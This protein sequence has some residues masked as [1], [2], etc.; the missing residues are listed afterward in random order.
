MIDKWTTG[1]VIVVMT[2]MGFFGA[3]ASKYKNKLE[4]TESDLAAETLRADAYYSQT[5]ALATAYRE[6]AENINDV[7]TQHER[8][9]RNATTRARAAERMLE[10]IEVGECFD[11]PIAPAVI[12][13]LSESACAMSGLPA[14]SNLPGDTGRAPG[15]GTNATLT[16][17]D[18]TE[19]ALSAAAG[20]IECNGKLKA[21]SQL[22]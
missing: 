11:R 9:R 15:T 8:R 17:R 20:L 5:Q 7:L 13:G 14:A 12:S 4:Q 3:A 16:C 2:L 10:T 1:F 22:E 18:I 6:Q 19:Y 21:I